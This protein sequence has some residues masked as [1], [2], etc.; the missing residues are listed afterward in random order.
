MYGNPLYRMLLDR[1]PGPDRL[2]L[3]IA[4]PWPGN[5]E[6]GQV[7]IG[8]QTDLFEHD[9]PENL[10]KSR[11]VL[12]HGWLRDLRAVG[13]EAARRRARALVKEWLER[14]DVW[15]EDSWRP[16]VLGERLVN[17]VFFTGF[18]AAHASPDF[19][20]RLIASMMR[21]WRH[22]MRTMPT[23]L[24]GAENLCALKG[25]LAAD[26]ALS[27]GDRASGLALELMRRQLFAEILADG[28]H[29][30]R[31][32]AM[33]LNVLRH[34][35]DI[36]ALLHAARREAPHELVTAIER[37]VPA[38]KLFRH[39]DG[40]LALFNGSHEA[41]QLETE[42][43]LT[44]SGAR[45]RVLRRLAQTGYERL[46]A[47]RSLLL[48][49]TGTPPP[50]PFDK[51]AHAGLLSFEF[52]VGRERLIVN[53]GTG[54]DDAAEWRTAMAATA[55]HSTL[56]LSDTNAC[57]VLPE[58]GIGH[59]PKPAASQRYEQDGAHYVEAMH[60]GYEARFHV[61][62][63]RSLCLTEEG[64]KLHGRDVLSGPP[65]RDFALR[66]H[67]HPS[68]QVAL[69]Q[70]GQAALL[71]LPSGSGWRL[72]MEGDAQ[73]L[74]LSLEPSVYGGGPGPRRTLQIKVGGRMRE[75][76]TVISWLLAREKTG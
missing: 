49:D 6:A 46:T 43:V 47:G 69:A 36:R 67:L 59:R 34:L 13:T 19:S 29:V 16:D 60:N 33:Q 51:T 14:H 55:A 38:L 18:F 12:A 66:W 22:L 50:W 10:I 73:S 40:C 44:L 74:E 64:E 5:A 70:G 11:Y 75:D 42:A 21:Q 3:S 26:L 27:D 71:R 15:R 45:G 62:H 72:R 39:G 17:W 7:L 54:P 31:N 65:G 63:H 4:D 76:P 37:M 23:N 1:E 2:H 61:A 53:C 41:S 9:S 20:S 30:S 25:L 8:K 52:S 32:P 28:G 57:E 58:G 68:V 56:T 48:V 35:I 24:T